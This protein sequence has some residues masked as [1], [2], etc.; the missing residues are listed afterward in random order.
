MAESN[1]EKAEC[2]EVIA[3]CY[4]RGLKN[5]KESIKYYLE[6]LKYEK[7]ND[8]RKILY[9]S[10]GYIYK[11]QNN[12]NDSIKN[13]IEA[14]KLSTDKAKKYKLNKNIADIYYTGKKQYKECATYYLDAI[15]NASGDEEKSNCYM[16][17]GYSMSQTG[18]YKEAANHYKSAAQLIKDDDRMKCDMYR[19]AGDMCYFRLVLYLYIYILLLLEQL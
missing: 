10:L 15:K 11:T 7:N 3:D 4:F 2:N 1:E 9:E 17:L 14:L 6:S 18:K 16:C 5:N 19:R 13:Y 8:V 12:F